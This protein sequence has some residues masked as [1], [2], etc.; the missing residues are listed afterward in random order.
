MQRPVP[1]FEIVVIGAGV[2]GL[3]IAA[4]LARRG[5]SVLILERE[6]G[7][8]R[9]ISSRNSE[10]IHAGIYYPAATLKAQMCVEGR[11]RLYAWCEQ[12][13][14][15]HRRLGKLIVATADREEPIL[16]DLLA[17]GRA[18]GVERL[19]LID[20]A[21][22]AALEPGIVARAALYSPDTGIV[23]GQGLCLSLLAE[24]ESAGA[25]LALAR[26]VE[27]LEPRSYGWRVEVRGDGGGVEGVD[28]GCVVDAAGLDADRIAALAGLPI[29]RLR[30]RQH[31]CKGDYFS[32]AA[33]GPDLPEHL[34]YPVPQQVGLGIH[35][36]LDLAG[37]IRFGPD[38]EYVMRSVSASV[39]SPDSV[40]VYDY[41]VDAAKAT[42]FRDAVSRYWPAVGEAELLPD[43]AGIRPRLAGPGDGFRDFVVEETSDHAVPGFIACIGIESPGLTAALALAERVAAL[44]SV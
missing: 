2:I 16:E 26:R 42:L 23:D 24:A 20:A 18:N 7:I 19:D 41:D 5:R 25:A 3:A 21:A 8:A 37:R 34:I 12:K 10:V 22:S 4:K 27:G 13:R 15:A 9:G 14:V 6:K 33:G 31:P 11:E 32:L 29:D 36:T 38:A 30:W 35:A 40:S 39:P 28:T 17:R 44:E 1:G 43:Y